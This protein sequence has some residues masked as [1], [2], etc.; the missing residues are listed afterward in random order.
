MKIIYPD[1]NIGAHIPYEFSHIK[2]K[3][4]FELSQKVISID[5][6]FT[7]TIIGQEQTSV[8]WELQ[9]IN[10]IAGEKIRSVYP[11]YKQLNILRS[12]N[13][14]QIN[15]MNMFIN[16]VRAWAN[17]DAPDPWDGSLELIVPE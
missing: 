8:V 2:T 5:E 16:A 4:Q 9:D 6:N 1:G 10:Y 14:E 15:K 12:G 7:A 11:E 3:E 17:S 13:Q